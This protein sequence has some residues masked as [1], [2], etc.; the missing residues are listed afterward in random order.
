MNLS[1]VHLW[2]FLTNHTSIQLIGMSGQIAVTG[3][4][5]K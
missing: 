2:R 3:A 4:S 1:E 5:V